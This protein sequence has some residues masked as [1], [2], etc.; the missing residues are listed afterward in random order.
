MGSKRK[1]T[2]MHSTKN[3]TTKATWRKLYVLEF[4]C[5]NQLLPET[6]KASNYKFTAWL[7]LSLQFKGL[8]KSLCCYEALW[9]LQWG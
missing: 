3:T 1:H 7:E 2:Y 4:L 8:L 9:G 5:L 6:M